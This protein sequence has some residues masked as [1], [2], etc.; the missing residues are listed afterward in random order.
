MKILRSILPAL[1]ALF[2]WNSSAQVPADI[3]KRKEDIAQYR[4]DFFDKDRA[5]STAARRTA[6]QR[7]VELEKT[8]GTIDQAAFELSLARI[9]A[10]ADNGH[11]M[12]F[13]GP[14]SHRAPA[15]ITAPAAFSTAS[16]PSPST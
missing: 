12:S 4:R 3:D 15:L 16:F 14:R 9:T 11:T 13:A 8:V 6:E 7:L 5:Y 2:A 10:L 1:L